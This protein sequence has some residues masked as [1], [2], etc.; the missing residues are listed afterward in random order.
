MTY[1]VVSEEPAYQSFDLFADIGGIAGIR[2][3]V[4]I[5]KYAVT[6]ENHLR[7][8]HRVLY[9]FGCRNSSVFYGT[10]LVSFKKIQSECSL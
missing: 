8:V 4:A 1:E 10:F 9:L 6:N 7:F 2:D 5:N 3:T